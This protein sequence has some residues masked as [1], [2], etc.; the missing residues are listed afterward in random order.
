M[1]CAVVHSYK[2][3]AERGVQADSC[4]QAIFRAKLKICIEK[5]LCQLLPVTTAGNNPLAL[6]LS[7][8][9]VKPG[10]SS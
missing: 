7:E 1:Q 3:N 10:A 9:E 4:T 6:F 8:K 2:E 5:T